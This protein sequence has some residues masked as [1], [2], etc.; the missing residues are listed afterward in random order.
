LAEEIISLAEQ[1]GIDLII[2]GSRGLGATGRFSLGGTA[3]QIISHAPCSTLIAR[4]AQ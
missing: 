2:I 4:A 3:M 1:E